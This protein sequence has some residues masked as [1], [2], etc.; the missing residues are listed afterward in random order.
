[1]GA[2]SDHQVAA[3][4]IRLSRFIGLLDEMSQ[5][6]IVQYDFSVRL[7]LLFASILRAR[8]AGR[9]V[10]LLADEFCVEEIALISRTL[11]EI[12]V[13]AAYLQYAEDS[14]IDRYLYSDPILVSDDTARLRHT[15]TAHARRRSLGIARENAVQTIRRL[16]RRED[17]H[18]W[19]KKTLLQRVDVKS[20]TP[21]MSLLV[22]TMNSRA[23]AA[24][25]NLFSSLA[26]Y[27]TA[28]DTMSIVPS[29]NR[30][31]ELAEALFG[32]NLSLMTLSLYLN[33]FLRLKADD[34]IEAA[35]ASQM[36]LQKS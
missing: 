12:V 36:I 26:P 33:S 8:Q 32:V 23:Q 13:N 29:A 18:S 19:S 20:D 21:I 17:D 14:E 7:A 6:S 28:L 10:E 3:Q 31:S 34:A 24:S 15:L 27:L 11:I 4:R 22:T 25:L 9:S 30:Q 2:G 35:G 16:I 1:M 5:T